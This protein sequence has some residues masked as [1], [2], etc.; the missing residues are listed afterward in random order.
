MV[1]K[2]I[3]DDVKLTRN[4]KTYFIHKNSGCILRVIVERYGLDESGVSQA[5]RRLEKRKAEN[6]ARKQVMNFIDMK[7][8]PS[9]V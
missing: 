4:V 7:I 8:K 5:R 3:Q 9:R 1:G 2:I 6:D